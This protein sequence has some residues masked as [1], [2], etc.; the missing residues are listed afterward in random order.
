MALK[1]DYIHAHVSHVLQWYFGH[2]CW[3]YGCVDHVP[4]PSLCLFTC[5]LSNST[6]AEVW[7][8]ISHHI[9]CSCAVHIYHTYRQPLWCSSAIL[10]TYLYKWFPCFD[11]PRLGYCWSHCGRLISVNILFV[12]INRFSPHYHIHV[13]QQQIWF[14]KK[15]QSQ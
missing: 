5:S 7:A 13:Q 3:N 4:D 6:L 15:I 2:R 1:G 10:H 11:W 9:H 12:S 14:R 8:L